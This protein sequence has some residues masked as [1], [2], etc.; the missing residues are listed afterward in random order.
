MIS[1]S[2]PPG[3]SFSDPPA[4]AHSFIARFTVMLMLGDHTTGTT[5]AASAMNSF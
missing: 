3:V 4:I 2:H 5:S 1:T